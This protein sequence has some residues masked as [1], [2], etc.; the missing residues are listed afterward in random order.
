MSRVRAPL[1]GRARELGELRAAFSD[2][3]GGTPR[4]L[5]VAGEA[6]IG[7]SRLLEEFVAQVREAD[8]ALVVSG[9][10][11]DSGSGPLPY[12]ALEGVLRDV[13]GALGVER[14]L[15]AAGPGADALGLVAPRL[16]DV[17]TDIS[18]GRLPEVVAG[19]LAAVG[20]ERPV[21][22]VVEDLHWADEATRATVARL[23]R[24]GMDESVLL[25]LSYRSDDVGRGHPLRTTLAE[26]ERARLVTRVDL[27]RLD[28]AEIA[29]LAAA[30][31]DAEDIG[32]GLADLVD[33]SE[34]VPFFVEE[35][36]G[37]LGVDLPDSLRDVLLLR[38]SRLSPAAREFCRQVAAAGPRAP[39]DLLTDAL[40]ADAVAAS[41][42]VARE[43]VEAAVLVGDADAYAFRH[44]LVQEAVL[45]ELL[46]GERRRLH[47]AYAEALEAR[48]TSVARLS[49][50]ADH[51]WR[52]RVLDRALA[53]AVSGHDAA[54][55]AGA[56]TT[57]A[58]LGERALELW[59]MV[60][61]AEAVAGVPHHAMLVRVAQSVRSMTRLDRAL[62]LCHQAL[63]EWPDDDPL[64]LAGALDD[65]SVIAAQ[66]GS[67]EGRA[68]LERALALV[69][70]G[71]HDEV[72]ARL[73]VSKARDAM[74][75]GRSAEGITTATECY[76]TAMSVGAS[77][78][79]SI[80]LNMRGVSRVTLG[81]A[82]GFDDLE[83]CRELA[84]DDFVALSRYY[85]NAS[86]A[87]LVWGRYEDALALA[88]EG[89]RRSR[90]LGAGWSSDAM[91]EGNAAEAQLALGEWDTAAAWY[92]RAVPLV[93]TST[94][95]VY[96]RE[97]WA[98]LLMWRG[99]VP[100]AEAIVRAKLADWERFGRLEE[101]VR[102]RVAATLAELALLRGDAEEALRLISGVVLRPDQERNPAYQ[103][104]VLAVAARAIGQLRRSAGAEAAGAEA[105]DAE[106]SGGA[107]PDAAPFQ[108]QVDAYAE[109]PTHPLWSALFSAELGEGPWSAVAESAGPAH[110]RPYALYRD[111]VALLDAGERAAARDRLTEAVAAARAIGCGLV[112][113]Q[114]E[115][116]LET[117]GLRAHRRGDGEELTER[118]RQVLELVAEG[119]TNGQVAERLFI[120]PKTA[121]VHVSAI[122]RKLGVSSRTEAAVKARSGTLGE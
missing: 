14:T 70:P 90:A 35:L 84:A 28:D 21:V 94:F 62:A 23:A 103:L 119:L 38:Y 43:A 29:Q 37:F 86:E 117:G 34:G 56:W 109:W 93:S 33:R 42:P 68:F 15:E 69:P 116:L 73:L 13:V 61:D 18:P 112:A 55:R 111:G 22:V 65:A 110:L 98:W 76:E 104:P 113:G 67:V 80:A 66:A 89:A 52:A 45:T 46:P 63:D 106:A 49:E 47:A 36:V 102:T 120:S 108:A 48:P 4:T 25:V 17:R 82:G 12:A 105:P 92:E 40:G 39:Y 88:E 58:A 3:R 71:E 30:L 96:L 97:R 101:Q 26:L 41:E 51:W 20:R 53:A 10:C 95:A 121:S 1:V 5:V 87:R 77:R 79:A 85:V 107:V 72:R 118:E 78:E 57:A 122:L 8:E 50:I 99:D 16:I 44:A 2:V 54:D 7:K 11:A 6:G 75:D 81:D 74:L 27:P 115:E 9:A 24:M 31:L 100:A 91:L 114:A 64:G 60:P 59:E 83:R 32:P 19:L